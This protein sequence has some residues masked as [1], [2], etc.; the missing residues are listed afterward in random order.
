MPVDYLDGVV[1]SADESLLLCWA[2]NRRRVDP[3][4]GLHGQRHLLPVHPVRSVSDAQTD[5]LT[6][7][8]YLWRWDT[9]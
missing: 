9:D 7:H 2:V 4:V 3:V 6:I 8:D 5:R 1:F